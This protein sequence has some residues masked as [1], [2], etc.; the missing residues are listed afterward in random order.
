MHQRILRRQ[1]GATG[2]GLGRLTQTKYKLTQ[3]NRKYYGRPKIL[4]KI[5]VDRVDAVELWS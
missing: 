5:A 4:R 2:R 3:K 1:G